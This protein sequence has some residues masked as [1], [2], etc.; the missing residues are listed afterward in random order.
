MQTKQ[1]AKMLSAWLSPTAWLLMSAIMVGPVMAGTDTSAD[2]TTRATTAEAATIRAR[3]SALE[4]AAADLTG[5]AEAASA[6][7]ERLT[8]LESRLKAAARLTEVPADQRA[9]EALLEL[10]EALEAY[11]QAEPFVQVARTREAIAAAR[12]AVWTAR[13]GLDQ[14]KLREP[15]TD[16]AEQTEITLETADSSRVTRAQRS[17]ETA[18]LRVQS[19]TTEGSEETLGK[20]LLSLAGR[21]H[22]ALMDVL[23]PAGEDGKRALPTV[24]D[25]LTRYQARLEPL[26]KLGADATKPDTPETVMTALRQALPRAA[27]MEVERVELEALVKRL[28]QA[29]T[30]AAKQTPSDLN[31]WLAKP[32]AEFTKYD[33]ATN[34]TQFV[35]NIGSDLEQI[36]KQLDAW[37]AT[38]KQ[39]AAATARLISEQALSVIENPSAQLATANATVSQG[40]GLASDLGVVVEAA[41]ALVQRRDLRGALTGEAIAKL[42]TAVRQ[43]RRERGRVVLATELVIEAL[44]GDMSRWVADQMPLYYFGDVRRLLT[45]L[46][47]RVEEHGANTAAR[48]ALA[49]ARATLANAEFGVLDAQNELSRLR[50]RLRELRDE[51]ANAESGYGVVAAALAAQNALV[52]RLTRRHDALAAQQGSEDATR[53]AARAEQELTRAK[54]RQKA[55]A[56]QETEADEYRANLSAEGRNLPGQIEEAERAVA[57]ANQN[58]VMA[59]RAMLTA[60]YAESDAF[61]AARDSAP[62]LYAPANAASTDPIRRCALYAFADRQV[63]FIRGAPSDVAF[64][65]QIVAQF[66]RP[67]PQAS[68][69]LWTLEMTRQIDDQRRDYEQMNHA[70]ASVN[71]LLTDQRALTTAAIN[72]LRTAVNVTV[73]KVLTGSQNQLD[74]Y[75]QDAA[76]SA[77]GRVGQRL[78]DQLASQERQL[79]ERVKSNLD[80]DEQA[81]LLAAQRLVERRKDLVDNYTNEYKEQADTLTLVKEFPLPEQD[82]LF[83]IRARIYPPEVQRRLG[84]PANDDEL[85]RYF[86]QHYE[87]LIETKLRRQLDV[88]DRQVLAELPEDSYLVRLRL[89]SWADMSW[90]RSHLGEGDQRQIPQPSQVAVPLSTRLL[91]ARAVMPEPSAT[92]T[93]GETLLVLSLLPVSKQGEV[94]KAFQEQLQCV[95]QMSAESRQSDSRRPVQWLTIGEQDRLFV[96]LQRAIGAGPATG[97]AD[98][99]QDQHKASLTPAQFELVAALQRAGVERLRRRLLALLGYWETYERAR[100]EMSAQWEAVLKQVKQAEHEWLI[101]SSDNAAGSAAQR[102]SEELS[103]E[104]DRLSTT[105]GRLHSEQWQVLTEF[106]QIFDWMRNTL[107]LRPPMPVG[108]ELTLAEGD[109]TMVVALLRSMLRNGTDSMRFESASTNAR[110]AAADQLLKELIIAF[111]D[112]LERHIRQP[113]L[114]E[115]RRRLHRNGLNVG[116]LQRT[117]ILTTNRL[118]ARVDPR[119]TAHLPIGEEQNV[120]DAATQYAQLYLAAST[121]G[122]TALLGAF[123]GQLMRREERPPEIY[124]IATGN[125]F[126]V[127]PVI[128]PSGQALRFTF[129]YVAATAV[130][131]PNGAVNP[132]VPRVERHTVNTEVQLSS[133]EIREISRFA[134]NAQ[135]G[136]PTQR[137]GGLPLLKDIDLLRDIPLIGWFRKRGGRGAV[138]QESLIMAQTTVYPT[139]LEMSAL[140]SPGMDLD[141]TP[142][143]E[144]SRPLLELA[145]EVRT[146]RAE[147]QTGSWSPTTRTGRLRLLD[148]ELAGATA[149]FLVNADADAAVYLNDEQDND[150]FNT[151]VAYDGATGRLQATNLRHIDAEKRTAVIYAWSAVQDSGLLC[152]LAPDGGVGSVLP[153]RSEHLRGG[154]SLPD[155]YAVAF[156]GN[157]PPVDGRRVQVVVEHE[158]GRPVRVLT[159]TPAPSQP[160]E[161]AAETPTKPVE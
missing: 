121:G 106:T 70:L 128:D 140:L 96:Q 150:W 37:L 74:A 146:Y 98:S 132:Q 18:L 9:L 160:V 51:Q 56:E 94:I 85:K 147:L 149:H 157:Q 145:P 159:V 41:E 58:V 103:L 152:L 79:Q 105:L 73:Q 86:S 66:D 125:V 65:K 107:D 27:A 126:Q 80:E 7:R 54:D 77:V 72:A 34:L 89:R 52:T 1:H 11:A 39:Q 153:F 114:I 88:L 43:L 75:K 133:M 122:A 31:A 137:S 138:A 22:T 55:L 71:E 16:G 32:T 44:A 143:P 21:L 109:P 93:L 136:I 69:V 60:A 113:A 134:S 84:L 53:Q 45:M 2:D 19:A 155:N 5:K 33:V 17:G 127:T 117:S 123:G 120:I 15:K 20:E 92:T 61:A 68:L 81:W 87:D 47:P 112:D 151:D 119:A 59:R 28:A 10:A 14:S 46:N 116:V 48:E 62:Y 67:Q 12:E 40:N 91:V 13:Q 50:T 100:M 6:L 78:K 35:Q 42:E 23:G 156:D 29:A 142:L 129:D 148:G 115:L 154:L 25:L 97:S 144:T 49:A 63:L 104:L 57:V 161:P 95:L 26:T 8:A 30:N 83:I 101:S 38:A 111:E 24:H 108:G 141:G 3:A 102:R 4:T 82:E 36:V 90:Y 76:W 130:R 135:L 124:A 64:V 110:I 139:I 158:A 99:G 118:L 131:E